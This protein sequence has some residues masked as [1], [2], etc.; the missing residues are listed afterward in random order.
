VLEF[1][2]ANIISAPYLYK[3]REGE[4]PRS[5]PLNN[6]SEF[7]RFINMRIRIPNTAKIIIIFNIENIVDFFK[8]FGPISPTG[9][10][11]ARHWN[12][13]RAC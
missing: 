2:F 12:R 10:S 9:E 5:V 3:K 8:G 11:V 1:S 6:G 7:G 13:Q 4:G